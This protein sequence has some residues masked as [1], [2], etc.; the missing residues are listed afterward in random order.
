VLDIADFREL[1]GRRPEIVDAIETEGK[2]RREE[3]IAL[4]RG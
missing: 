3:N 2:R 1:A 4:G